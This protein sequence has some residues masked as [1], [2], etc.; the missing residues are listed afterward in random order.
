MENGLGFIVRTLQVSPQSTLLSVEGGFRTFL[1]EREHN[2]Q[3]GVVYY[4]P[5]SNSYTQEYEFYQDS[6]NTGIN[7]ITYRGSTVMLNFRYTLGIEHKKKPKTEPVD[8]EIFAGAKFEGR[9][10]EIQ[11]SV[12]TSHKSVRIKVWDL[13]DVDGDSITLAI[14]GSI[15]VEHLRLQRKKRTFRIPLEPGANLLLMYAENLG[16]IPPNT[17]AIIVRYGF[18]KKRVPLRSDMGMSGALSIERNH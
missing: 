2:V 7:R 8:P 9:S 14:N 3:A 17:A 5:L 18:R 10:V 15:I 6:V 12:E 1:R 13:G 11:E 4:H 16:T